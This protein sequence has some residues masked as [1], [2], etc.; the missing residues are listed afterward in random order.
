MTQSLREARKALADVVVP[1]LLA[2]GCLPEAD[3]DINEANRAVVRAMLAEHGTAWFGNVNI[4]K[5]Q[6]DY[7]ERLAEPLWEGH[8]VGTF[9]AS[10]V[11]PRYDAT[12]S[13]LIRERARPGTWTS[14]AADAPLVEAI[15]TAIEAAGGCVLTWT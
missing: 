12:V 2:D 5:S 3:E 11:L 10:F 13:R 7:A 15:H 14:V 9:G 8:G 4:Y 6:P 1:H